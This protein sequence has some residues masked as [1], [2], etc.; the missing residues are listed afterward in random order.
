MPVSER[1][2][3]LIVDILLMAI[4]SNSTPSSPNVFLPSP[5]FTNGTAEFLHRMFAIS[6]ALLRFI[7][8]LSKCNSLK[9]A[10]PFKKRPIISPTPTPP[11]LPASPKLGAPSPNPRA[12]SVP[13]SNAGRSQQ[14]LLSPNSIALHANI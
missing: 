2:T 5:K 14:S 9:V 6:I 3:F 7:P 4:D 8:A 12:D 10:F 11:N 13:L 1:F